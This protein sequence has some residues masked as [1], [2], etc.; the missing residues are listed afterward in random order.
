MLLTVHTSRGPRKVNV[1]DY[2]KASCVPFPQ[3]YCS[4]FCARA[5]RELYRARA[6]R[7]SE[8]KAETPVDTPGET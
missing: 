1:C 6:L 7:E 5:A 8:K 4:G 3:R 2:C